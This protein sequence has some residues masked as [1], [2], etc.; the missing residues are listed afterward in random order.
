MIIIYSSIVKTSVIYSTE[1]QQLLETN[2][3]KTI[4]S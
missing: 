1:K 4:K 2:Y 3:Q